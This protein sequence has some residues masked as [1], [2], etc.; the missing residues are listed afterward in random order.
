VSS[1]FPNSLSPIVS[2][3]AHAAIP[4]ALGAKVLEQLAKALM[5]DD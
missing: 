5:R 3:H 2:A 1:Q 4:L